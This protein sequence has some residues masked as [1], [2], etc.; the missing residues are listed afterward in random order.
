M[1]PDT[2]RMVSLLIGLVAVTVLSSSVLTSPFAPFP[3][4]YVGVTAGFVPALAVASAA[5]LVLLLT[6]NLP[7]MVTLWLIFFG[8]GLF[9]LHRSL[10]SR[11][12][13]AGG[14]AFYPVERVI[15]WAIA[16]GCV[17]ALALFGGTAGLEGGLAGEGARLVAGNPD[18]MALLSRS[19]GP[20]D[21]AR[22]AMLLRISIIT[23]IASWMLFLL[24]ALQGAQALASALGTNMRPTPNYD[25]LT[26]PP[27]FDIAL[28]AALLTSTLTQGWFADLSASIAA[29]LLSAYF[30]LGLAGLHAI[31]RGW[32]GRTAFLV[33]LYILIPLV[34]WV[35]IPI[36]IY[37]LFRQRIKNPAGT[38][39]G[40][41]ADLDNGSGTS[42]GNEEKD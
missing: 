2:R 7:V 38:G 18:L 6:G 13:G 14:Y 33:T 24:G 25:N 32:N 19:Y 40:D 17:G 27:A 12:D 3:L 4:M 22:I 37:G 15:M 29:I 34:I 28:A 21:E 1:T 5:S 35:I 36:S 20:I 16:L 31:S 42:G 30:L 9:L 10:L 39:G 41:D 8:P 26:L 23:S 11:P